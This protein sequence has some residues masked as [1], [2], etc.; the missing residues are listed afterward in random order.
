[1][2]NM[3]LGFDEFAVDMPR[4]PLGLNAGVVLVTPRGPVVLKQMR[5]RTGFIL[6]VAACHLV[7]V[8]MPPVTLLTWHR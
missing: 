6:V 2:P 3:A 7:A 4:P 1:M 5:A 8:V